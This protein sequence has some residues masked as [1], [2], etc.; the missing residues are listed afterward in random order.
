MAEAPRSLELLLSCQVCFEDFEEEGKHIP[1]LLPCTHTLCHTCIGHLIQGNKI[2]CPECRGKHEAKKEEKSFPQNKYILTQIKR[3]SSQEQPK[4]FEFQKCEEHIKELSNLFCKEFGCGKPICRLCLRKHHKK[5][6]VV[7]IE[8]QEKDVVIRDLM[9]IDMN[10]ETKV[11][12]MSQAKKNI[13]ERTKSV[14]EEIKKKKEEF[15]RYFEKIIKE[16][17]GQNKLQNMLIDDEISAMNSN[18]ELLRSLRE[19]IE[20]EE[21]IN[22]EEILNSRET[23]KG[24]I[25]NIN[26]NLSGERSF[27]YP[28]V[29]MGG[30]S[31]DEIL[32]E[33][34]QDEI[35][36]CLPDAPKQ[37]AGILIPRAIKDATELKC[38]GTFKFLHKLVCLCFLLVLSVGK[39]CPYIIFKNVCKEY[40]TFYLISIK[41]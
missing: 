9:R 31:A 39:P 35:T 15:D 23:V 11:D 16:V 36:V 5:H 3:K 14:T 20:N 28:V 41:L 22:C 13:G 26:V 12:M 10:L 24:I 38:T 27:E 4:A 30:S 1:R 33:V 29:T 34:T 37:I 7:N 21:E 25:E 8:E 18:L 40:P 32:E 2:E 17:E 6:D 19:N